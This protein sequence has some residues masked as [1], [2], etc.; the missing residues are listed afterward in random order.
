MTS[1]KTQNDTHNPGERKGQRVGVRP[2]SKKSTKQIWTCR[3]IRARLLFLALMALYAPPLPAPA[4]TLHNA[5]SLGEGQQGGM[6][7][8]EATRRG[9]HDTA[10]VTGG[11]LSATTA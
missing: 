7:L 11:I 2:V 3:L 6:W 4:F 10:E 8:A 9:K 1:P 5:R